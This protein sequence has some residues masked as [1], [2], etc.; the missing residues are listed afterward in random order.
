MSA[1]PP[2]TRQRPT[3]YYGWVIVGICCLILAVV[4]GIRLSFGVFFVALVSEFGW[5]HADTASIFS[6]SMIVFA[7]TSTLAGRALDRWGVRRVFGLGAAVLA[8][9]LCSAVRPS[10]S[11]SWR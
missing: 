1:V 8:L 3:R 5:S 11:G 9:G 7:G 4:F 6:I 2:P 10:R